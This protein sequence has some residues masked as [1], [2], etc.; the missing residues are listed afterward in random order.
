MRDPCSGNGKGEAAMRIDRLLVQQGLCPGRD[1]AKELIK[2]GAVTVN[3]QIVTKASQEV[4]EDCAIQVEQTL[5]RYVSRG[6][7]KLEK[8]LAVFP[9]ALQGKSCMD[10]GASAGGFTD[11]MLQNGAAKVIAVDVGEG[12]LAQSLREDSRV[13][14]LENTNIRSLSPDS[15][16]QGFDF[17]SV[18][19]SFLS[20]VHVFP[21]LSALL[22]EEGEAVCLVKPQFEAGREAV[23]KGGVVKG[24]KIHVR[25][26]R[27]VLE[28]AKSQG[29]YPAGLTFSPV[30]GP[31]GN[32]EYL[33]FLQK[34][35]V[36][37]SFEGKIEDVVAEAHQTLGKR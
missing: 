27:D 14:N 15:F 36:F 4:P 2:N 17:I 33:L 9:I 30:K 32:V 6:G 1:R 35:P 34:R 18:D 10:I 21:V 31:N 19:V 29:L 37:P 20:L 13:L 12:Q 3:K 22:T 25:V 8:A 16:P 7:F 11:C 26:L 23:G 5:L 28:N 24:E